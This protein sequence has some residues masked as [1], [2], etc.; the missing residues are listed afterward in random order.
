MYIFSVLFSFPFTISRAGCETGLPTDP[1]STGSAAGRTGRR[2][3][4]VGG[5]SGFTA[6]FSVPFPPSLPLDPS[7]VRRPKA[8]RAQRPLGLGT[9]PSLAAAAAAADT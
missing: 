2:A 1:R 7:L 5:K 6:T 8:S 9:H 4:R 3:R